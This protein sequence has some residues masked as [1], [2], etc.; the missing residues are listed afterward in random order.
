VGDV[1]G[2]LAHP[3]YVQRDQGA[4]ELLCLLYVGGDVIVHEEDKLLVQT[5]DFLHDLLRRTPRLGAFEVTL[6]GAK[7]APKLTSASGFHEPDGQVS[8]ARED[9]SVE[10]QTI[11]RGPSGPSVD[12]T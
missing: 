2:S 5:A 11:E 12:A 8:L 4:E 6:D 1:Y 9:R 3:P 10:L 7:L